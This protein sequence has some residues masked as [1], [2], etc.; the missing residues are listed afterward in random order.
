MMAVLNF[1]K[2]ILMFSLI[3]GFM[4]GALIVAPTSNP[5]IKRFQSAFRPSNDPSYNVRAE[6]QKRIKPYILA[7]P[8]GGGLGSVGIW[9]RRFA[10]NSMLAK[11]PPDSGYVRV[12]VEMGWIGLIL[13]CTLVFIVLYN[14]INFFYLIKNPELKTYCMAMILIIFALNVGNFPQQALVQYPSNIL[15][16]LAIAILVV[17]KRLDNEEQQKAHTKMPKQ[18]RIKLKWN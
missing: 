10:P 7:H 16:Y 5:L 6:N 18:E 4:L 9:G 2:K 8:I 11:F 1:N 13:F 12:A 17:C 3:A 15:F 14:G